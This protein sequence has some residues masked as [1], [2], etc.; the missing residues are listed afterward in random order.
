MANG[1][2]DRKR[3]VKLLT[4]IIIIGMISILLTTNIIVDK[5][6][7]AL[8]LEA[9]TKVDE[10][11]VH[12]ID[13]GQ[14]ESFLLMQGDKTALIDC[15]KLTTGKN[16]VKYLNNIGITEIDYLIGTHPHEDHIGGMYAILENFEIGTIIFPK[17]EE[18]KINS[19]WY[20][21]LM[22]K[23]QK[24]EYQVKYAKKG[25]IYYIENAIMEVIEAETNP[26]ENINNYS[27]V[28]KVSFGEIDILMTGDAEKEIEE[29]ILESGDNIDVEIL[30]VGHHGSCTSTME[31]FLDEVTPEYALISCK[32][33]N[34]Y[35]HPVKSTMEK[36]QERNIEVYRTDE[37]GSVI[38]TITANDVSFNCEPGDYLTGSEL[39]EKNSIWKAIIRLMK[40]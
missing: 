20:K 8:Q 30:K 39:K 24:E 1:K 31:E 18:G 28:F 16:V 23:I 4:P 12:M 27:I 7:K 2:R 5:I 19:F 29:K 38:M 9:T 40:R 21:R 6:V 10:F 36:L 37:S 26:G 11:Q 33:R 32:I 35:G 3:L 14:A 34:E 13:V 15:G 22:N 17:V 25:D